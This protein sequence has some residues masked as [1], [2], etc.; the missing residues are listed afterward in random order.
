[1]VDSR[2]LPGFHRGVAV[3]DA[4]QQGSGAAGSFS[5]SIASGNA[6]HFPRHIAN[7]KSKANRIN[8]GM[9]S[10]ELLQTQL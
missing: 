2:V 5:G 8:R 10:S 6:I 9:E 7:S 4:V 1:M 3:M